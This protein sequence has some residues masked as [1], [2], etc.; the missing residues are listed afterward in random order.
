MTGKAGARK[1]S[2]RVRRGRRA[3]KTASKGEDSHLGPSK[4]FA[5]SHLAPGRGRAV[6]NA[7]GIAPQ[8]IGLA[9]NHSPRH[10]AGHR[11]KQTRW[12]QRV[13]LV[14]RP[15][16]RKPRLRAREPS[17]ESLLGPSSWRKW[18][19][20]PLPAVEARQKRG[21]R[22]P[23]PWGPWKEYY[24]HHPKED[25]RSWGLQGIGGPNFHH[26]LWQ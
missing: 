10:G 7:R 15:A 19:A 21:E 22:G 5:R 20:Q 25:H 17:P 14:L 3:I 18:L 8:G 26:W 11:N 13:L 9:W 4:H 16:A 6:G 1:S 2:E 12:E 24:C 23:W